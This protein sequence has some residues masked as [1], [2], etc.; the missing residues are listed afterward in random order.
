MSRRWRPTP[1]LAISIAIHIIV[2][3][4]LLVRP[5]LWLPVGSLL[6]ADHFLVLIACLLPRLS[7][8]GANMTRLPQEMAEQGL[9]ALTFDDGPDPEV[10]PR[11][12]EILEQHGDSATFF[13]VGVRAERHPDLVAKIVEHGHRVENHS[14]RHPNLFSF[15]PPSD[16]AADLEQSQQVLAETSG[17]RPTYFRAPAG[18]RNPWVD[19]LLHRFGLRLVS[20]TRRGF[21]TA[22]RDPS[23]VAR[24]LTRSVAAGDI[25]L[26]HDGRAARTAENQ[27]VVL[28]ALPLVID[29]LRAKGLRTTLLPDPAESY[30]ESGCS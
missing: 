28:D 22:D 26:L 13:C 4:V 15:L 23:R 9:V 19:P 12:L 11:V 3:V 2:V 14:Y 21:D 30:P 5:V 6:I 17:Q 27:P 10:T 8:V 20:W 25:L 29:A 7:W 18:I 24:R 1:F 16:M